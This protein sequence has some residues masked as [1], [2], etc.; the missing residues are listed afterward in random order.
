[1]AMNHEDIIFKTEEFAKSRMASLLPS[2]GW[3]HVQ[4]VVT[5][6]VK[7]G[8]KEKADPFIVEMS[9]LLHDIARGEEDA[10]RGKVCHAKRGAEV[11]SDF[12][13][14]LGLSDAVVEHIAHCIRAHRYRGKC[15]PKTKEAKVLFDADKL[16][17]IG[18]IG[19]GR[20]FLFSG[21]VGARL[22]NGDIDVHATEAYSEEDTAYREF[23]V[24]LR[25]VKKSL[26]TLEGRRLARG[27]HD[28]MKKYFKR[29]KEEALGRL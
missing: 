28:F 12:L 15:L 4:R 24:K 3:D 6:A 20:A 9:A 17:S 27:R 11:A 26:L 13:R 5:L 10:S 29:L 1:M 7:I 23:M 14:T 19:I 2:H 21:E 25:H 18:A 22:Y 16:D 8:K